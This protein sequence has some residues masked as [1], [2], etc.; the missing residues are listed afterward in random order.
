MRGAPVRVI[1]GTWAPVVTGAAV[2]PIPRPT[3]KGWG[4]MLPRGR[5]KAAAGF[6]GLAALSPGVCNGGGCAMVIAV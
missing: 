1:L 3:A 4:R 5:F 2:L 6:L